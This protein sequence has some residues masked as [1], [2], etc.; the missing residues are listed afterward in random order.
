MIGE[1]I[2]IEI[3]ATLD[4]LIRNAE[5]IQD[6]NTDELSTTEIDVFKKTQESLI[7]HLI[8]MDQRLEEKRKGLT[9]LD[10]RSASY[11]IKEKRIKFEHLKGA[12]HQTILE[13]E[14]QMP[15]LSKR[16]SKRFLAKK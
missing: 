9:T 14:N 7:Q 5:V 4:Q 3:D 1:E 2:L 8:H 13:K 11:K 6:A 15:L 16:R 12:Y 10:K